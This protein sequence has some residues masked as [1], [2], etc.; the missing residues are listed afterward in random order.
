MEE[1]SLF[2]SN[3][4]ADCIFFKFRQ[5]SVSEER[6]GTDFIKNYGDFLYTY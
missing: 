3:A 2:M 1:A 5:I 6:K 4:E